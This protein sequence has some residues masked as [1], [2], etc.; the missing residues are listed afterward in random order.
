MIWAMLVLGCNEYVVKK[1]PVDPPVAPP[2][3]VIDA[4]G[5]PPT[6]WDTCASGWFGQYENLPSN[7]PDIDP[8]T[9][10]PPPDDPDALDWWSSDYR[11]FQRYDPSIDF[12]PNW[13]PVD[14]GIQDDPR[15]FAV[16]WT[17]WVRAK[18]GTDM[19]FVLGNA[20]DAWLDIGTPGD[21]GQRVA[22]AGVHTFAPEEM[23]VHLSSGVYPLHL[24]YAQRSG[25]ADGFRFRITGGDVVLCYPTFPTGS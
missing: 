22:R 1:A 17:A 18:S 25:G 19:Q 5:K 24:R 3:D 10:T 16:S 23:S 20:D 12:G 4:Q 21:G 9:A 15:D 6:D 13:W 2:A 8:D 14:D 11:S 7:H